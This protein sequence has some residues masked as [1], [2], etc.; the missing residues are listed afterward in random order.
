[1]TYVL[2]FKERAAALLLYMLIRIFG[3]TYR[4]RVTGIE[5][6]AAAKS[7][8]PAGACALAMWHENIFAS[9]IY[10]RGQKLAPL[11]S[12][13]KDGAMITAIMER[14]GY[15]TVRGSS[16]KGGSEA[17]DELVVA[18]AEGF[19]PILTVDGPRGPRRVAKS[20]IIDIGRRTGVQIVPVAT[21]ARSSW[22][23]KSWDRFRIPK[24]FARVEV[25]FGEPITVNPDANGTAFGERRAA[26]QNALLS[27]Q[28]KAEVLAGI[29][30][31]D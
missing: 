1:L 12:H 18:V 17:R 13:S 3:M 29:P 6:F 4:F 25:L 14:L 27:T 31:G 2:S 9:L 26:A 24:P 19:S 11:A 22:V 5:N 16:S 20:G 30:H 15:R 21:V 10:F 28:L 7:T 8:Q 23:L